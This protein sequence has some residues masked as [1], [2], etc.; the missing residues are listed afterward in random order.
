[1]IQWITRLPELEWYPAR[2]FDKT[3]AF[4]MPPILLVVHSGAQFPGVAEYEHKNGGYPEPDGRFMH[5]CYHIAWSAVKSDFVQ[6]VDL[7]HQAW[8]AG[9]SKWSVRPGVRVNTLSL[10]IALPGPYQAERPAQMLD[11]VHHIAERLVCEI[12]SLKY[13]V[14]HSDIDHNKKDPGPHFQDTLF[15][16]LLEHKA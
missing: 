6:Q 7:D 4:S 5:T 10:S 13:W 1:M 11:S 9:G 14:R 12:P 8:H 3:D 2:W 16:G 15:D